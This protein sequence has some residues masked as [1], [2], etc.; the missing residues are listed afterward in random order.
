[1]SDGQHRGRIERSVRDWAAGTSRLVTPDVRHRASG[2]TMRDRGYHP[3]LDGVRGVALLLV[4]GQH[5]PSKPL[6]DGFS[7]IKDKTHWGYMF[8]FG[9]FQIPKSDFELIKNAMLSS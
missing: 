9:L 6:I 8:R 7:F 5:A 2:V 3:G 1:M 4:L